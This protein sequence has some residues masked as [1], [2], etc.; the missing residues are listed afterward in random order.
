MFECIPL[1]TATASKRRIHFAI[2]ED[3]G[4]TFSDLTV[5]GVKVPLTFADGTEANSTNDIVKESVGKFYIELTQSEAND[6]LG[7][8]FGHFVP[9]SCL[10]V[11]IEAYIVPANND[12]ATSS[13]PTD[14]ASAVRTELATELAEI[15]AIETLLDTEFPALTAAVADLPTNAELA[16]ALGSAD[17]AVLAALADL[18]TLIDTAIAAIGVVDGNVDSILADT[19]TDGV[20]VAAGSKTGYALSSAGIDAIWDEVME[21][22]H[23]GRHYM[24]GFASI[25]FGKSDDDG[26]TYRDIGDTKNRVAATVV[27][28]N[29]TAIV[30]D[31]T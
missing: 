2:V 27:G 31:L 29:R 17:D 4:L 24:K 26:L 11:I 13:G 30:L 20:V 8:V 23:T 5:T 14:I 3:D 7:I 6:G 16:T 18:D 22:T 25:L 1:N 10:P 28:S 15:S 21:G 9:S 19:G 12:P